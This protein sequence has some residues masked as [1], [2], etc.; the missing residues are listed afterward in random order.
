[1]KVH[2]DRT[3]YSVRVGTPI[4]SGVRLRISDLS[5]QDPNRR[6]WISLTTWTVG[7][8]SGRC[9]PRVRTKTDSSSSTFDHGPQ[10]PLRTSTSSSTTTPGMYH[11]YR[12]VEAQF[13]RSPNMCQQSMTRDFLHYNP[14]RRLFVTRDMSHI[15]HCGG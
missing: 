3:C 2:E 12:G 4:L 9:D 1:M 5:A 7:L 13:R 6:L 14:H 8:L 15:L 11:F 10:T